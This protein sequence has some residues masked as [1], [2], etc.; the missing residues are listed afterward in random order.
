MLKFEETTSL[1]LHGSSCSVCFHIHVYRRIL[2]LGFGGTKDP[3][4]WEYRSKKCAF[5]PLHYSILSSNSVFS[6]SE[7]I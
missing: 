4:V 2:G 1:E 7:Q 6:N 5:E 3:Q